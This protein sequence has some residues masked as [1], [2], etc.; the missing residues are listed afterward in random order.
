[1]AR[2]QV[3]LVMAFDGHYSD[4]RIKRISAIME[5]HGAAFFRRR[6][7]LEFGTGYVDVEKVLRS[8]GFTFI[9]IADDRCNANSHHYDWTPANSGGCTHEKRAFW[10]ARRIGDSRSC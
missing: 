7:L 10:F 8:Y 9:R 6:R 3:V 5:R 4:C 2:V 1:M